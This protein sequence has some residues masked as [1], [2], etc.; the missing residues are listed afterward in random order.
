MTTKEFLIHFEMVLEML[1]MD[2]YKGRVI[3]FI[4]RIIDEYAQK[5]DRP[6][7]NE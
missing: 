3:K 5:N 1:E 6:H 4:K 7:A 2:G